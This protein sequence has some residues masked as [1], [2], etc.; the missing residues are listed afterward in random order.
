MT[1]A[2]AAIVIREAIREAAREYGCKQSE[3]HM[4]PQA[5]KAALAARA[6]AIRHAY[7]QGVSK[8]DLSEAFS[9]SAETIK[10]TLQLTKP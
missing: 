3:V 4:P 9:R 7:D 1:T 6:V 8:H 10:K 2:Q 5:N